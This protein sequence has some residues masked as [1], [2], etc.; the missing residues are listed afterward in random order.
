MSSKNWIRTQKQNELE[1]SKIWKLQKIN[2][3]VDKNKNWK[4]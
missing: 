3:K 2:L 4:S 1:D